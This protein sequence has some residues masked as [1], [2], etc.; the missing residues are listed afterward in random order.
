M[1]SNAKSKYALKHALKHELDKLGIARKGWDLESERSHHAANGSFEA[2]G[3]FD[4][5]I[6][7]AKELRGG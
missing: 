7:R 3:I 6:N 5:A 2:V 1:F 4:E